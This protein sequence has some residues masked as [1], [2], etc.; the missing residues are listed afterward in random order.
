MLTEDRIDTTGIAYAEFVLDSELCDFLLGVTS[1]E[2]VPSDCRIH[3]K[4]DTSMYFCADSKAWPGNREWGAGAGRKQGDRVGLLVKQGSLYVYVNG[5]Q[6][7]LGPMVSGGLPPRVRFA[8]Y[9][10]QDVKVGV[11]EEVRCPE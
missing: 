5:L 9:I 10:W 11:M 6:L 3:N 8:A 1:L 2:S 7:G 4:A